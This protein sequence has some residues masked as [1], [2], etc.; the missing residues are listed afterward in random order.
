MRPS[1]DENISKKNEHDYLNDKFYFIKIWIFSILFISVLFFIYYFCNNKYNFIHGNY[2][3]HPHYN[4]KF[5]PAL[6][7]FGDC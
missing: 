3:S 2:L 1:Y 7:N 5:P 6:L 4:S